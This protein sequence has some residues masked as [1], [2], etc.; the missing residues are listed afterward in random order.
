MSATSTGNTP[1]SRKATA[2]HFASGASEVVK[3]VNVATIYVGAVMIPFKHRIRKASV[4]GAGCDVVGSITLTL[5]SGVD[6][7]DLSAAATSI[8]S[9]ADTLTDGVDTV[10]A[11]ELTIT[12]VN[13]NKIRAANTVYTLKVVG[14]NA[15]DTIRAL[16]FCLE[17]E[18]EG[19]RKG[20]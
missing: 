8:S 4:V 2:L 19:G 7:T 6:G 1:G 14:T 11:E 20:L 3:T 13:K 12:A 5:Q 10:I 15:A 18:P 16:G 9:G 17:V